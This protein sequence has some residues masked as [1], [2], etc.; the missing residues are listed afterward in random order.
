[1]NNDSLN[2]II[3]YCADIDEYDRTPEQQAVVELYATIVASFENIT[4]E[5]WNDNCKV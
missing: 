1:M 3:K 2:Q 4:G 5:R